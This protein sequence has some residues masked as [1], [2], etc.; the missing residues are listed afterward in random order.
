MTSNI[1]PNSAL[2][3]VLDVT[4]DVDGRVDA[5][6]DLIQWHERGGFLPR[7]TPTHLRAILASVLNSEPRS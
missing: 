4:L 5:I 7:L 1:D 2:D 6:V 3:R